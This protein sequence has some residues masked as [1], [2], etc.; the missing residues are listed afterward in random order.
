MGKEEDM[1]K[2]YV[3]WMHKSA[4]LNCGMISVLNN[5]RCVIYRWY[6]HT[7]YEQHHTC[8]PTDKMEVILRFTDTFKIAQ[9]K[10]SYSITLNLVNLSIQ[11]NI[12]IEF[13]KT[14]KHTETEEHLYTCDEDDFNGKRIL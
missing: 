5:M 9:H 1:Q 6:E 4:M 12:I 3:R 2:A 14:A 8:M 13:V 11:G 7:L 10:S